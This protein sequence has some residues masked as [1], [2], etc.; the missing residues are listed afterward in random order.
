MSDEPT[1]LSEGEVREIAR[2][3]GYDE[4]ELVDA[5]FKRNLPTVK[6][7]ELAHRPSSTRSS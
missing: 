4:D 1:D 3:F 2:E 5:I 6:A 7:I